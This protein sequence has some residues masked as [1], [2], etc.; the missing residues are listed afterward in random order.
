MKTIEVAFDIPLD[1]SFDYL[2]GEFL[3]Q[4]SPGVRVRVPFGRHKR[5]GLVLA[6]KE[7]EPGEREE[8]KEILSV[9]DAFPVVTEELFRVAEFLSGKY[10]SSLGQ[11]VFTMIGSLPVKY[12]I[13]PEYRGMM[14]LENSAP[15]QSAGFRKKYILAP[16]EKEKYGIYGRIIEDT[17]GSALCLFPEVAAAERYYE[18]LSVKHG[19]RAVLFHAGLKDKE[20]MDAW[21]KILSGGNLI[22]IGTRIAVFSPSR[23]IKAVIADSGGDSSY[24]E[25][26]TPKYNAVEIAEFRCISGQIPLTITEGCLSVGEYYEIEKGSAVLENCAGDVLPEV[27]T[28]FTG[29]RTVDKDMPFFASET[30]SL[31]EESVLKEG[32]VA[33]IHNRKGSSKILK[34][35]KCGSS[36]PCASCESSMVLSEDG[37]NLLCRFCKTTAPFGNKC[38]SCGSRKIGARLYGI[39]KIFRTLKEQYPEFKMAKFTAGTGEVKEEFD[40]IVGTSIVKRMFSAYNFSLVVLVS[41]ETFLNI[42]DYRSEEKFFIMINEMRGCVN[43]KDCKIIIQTRSPHL[44]VYEALRENDAGIFYKKE[45]G[46]RKNLG[47]P[48]FSEILKL[49][50]KAAK[51][52]VLEQRKEKVE[53]YLNE[54]QYAIIYSGPAFPPVKKSKNVWKYLLRMSGDFDRE[55]LRAAAQEVSATV[56][57]NP[58][59]V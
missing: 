1:K 28:V 56:E 12:K 48:P 29:R 33:V 55:G 43:N 24:S 34:C 23:D 8:Y 42:P 52:G 25:Q 35:E 10:F 54:K 51:K 17:K 26:Q 7:K 5:T 40:I 58:D 49:E 59:N 4:I 41:G 18:E 20:K 16:E 15:I 2:P 38:L 11:A 47:Y 19:D 44:E 53:K 22:I 9:C 3:P 13:N 46:I 39:E 36:F 21:L 32:K 50:I 45:L 57:T 6:V 14:P 30:V 37:K 31:I 27:Y